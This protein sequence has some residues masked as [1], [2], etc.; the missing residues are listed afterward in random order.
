MRRRALTT[1]A[2]PAAITTDEPFFL[3]VSCFACTAG[4]RV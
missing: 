4:S 2:A 1:A 3:S